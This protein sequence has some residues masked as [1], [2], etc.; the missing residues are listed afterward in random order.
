MA[1][2]QNRIGGSHVVAGVVVAAAISATLIVL[3][4]ALAATLGVPIVDLLVE[5]SGAA[6]AWLIA[7][8]ATGSYF[9]ARATVTMAHA[10]DR[11]EGALG[12]LLV[13]AAL[14]LLMLAIVAVWIAAAPI[15]ASRLADDLGRGLFTLVI[16]QIASLGTG[17]LGG[18]HR[19]GAPA[20]ASAASSQP[21]AAYEQEFFGATLSTPASAP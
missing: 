10:R 3:G 8:L 2:L 13:W 7:A 4:A 6:A 16:A 21:Y 1:W 20:A 12:G 11:R 19:R 18:L 17:L 15:A 5:R 14:S 9:G